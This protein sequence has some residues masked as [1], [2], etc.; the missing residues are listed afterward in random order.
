LKEELTEAFLKNQAYLKRLAYRFTA[1]SEKANDL[2]QETYLKALNHISY[3]R[4][5]ANFKTWLTKILV[6]TYFSKQRKRKQHVS[7]E[8]ER[9]AFSGN[10]INNPE[11]IVVKREL[12]WCVQHVLNHHL[13]ER[14][15][16]ALVLREINNLSYDEIAYSMGVSV[17]VVRSLIYRSKKSFRKHLVKTGCYLFVKE[18]SCICDGIVDDASFPISLDM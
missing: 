11:R 2:I 16:I 1:H 5:E 10:Y 3:F 13:Q 6:N 17:D 14:Y 15:R 8:L 9:I 4:G 18:Y 7:I 12:Q